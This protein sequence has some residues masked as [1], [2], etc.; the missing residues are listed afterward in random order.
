MPMCGAYGAA[1]MR[2][3]AG[4]G[5]AAD[6]EEAGERIRRLLADRH[7]PGRP[8]DVP[9][10]PAEVGYDAWA[11]T[12]DDP[13]N[14]LLAPDFERV[15]ALADGTPRGRALDAVCGTG[16]CAE[17]ISARGHD[18]VPADLRPPGS[19]TPRIQPGGYCAVAWAG[20]RTPGDTPTRR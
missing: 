4:D 5:T 14:G 2:A 12:Y 20:R 10:V 15:T 6:V 18:V 1:L 19:G 17:G 3:F 9:C 11:P 13:R 8:V 16:R 7:R